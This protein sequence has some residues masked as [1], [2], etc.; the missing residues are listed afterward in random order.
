LC[1]KI[2]KDLG[3]SLQSRVEPRE[4]GRIGPIRETMVLPSHVCEDRISVRVNIRSGALGR[5]H[6]KHECCSALLLGDLIVSE[7]RS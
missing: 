1:R 4:A 5:L 3:G 6:H 2:C 7:W